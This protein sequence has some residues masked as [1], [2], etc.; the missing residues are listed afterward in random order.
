MVSRLKLATLAVLFAA[1]LSGCRGPTE[2][3]SFIDRHCFVADWMNDHS[4]VSCRY[5]CNAGSGPTVS[6]VHEPI[7]APLDKSDEDPA[8]PSDGVTA[9]DQ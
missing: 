2:L 8:L 7:P 9:S 6:K 3:F 1:G 4:C 5:S